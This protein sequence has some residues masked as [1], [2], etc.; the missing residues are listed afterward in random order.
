M[1]TSRPGAPG[2]TRTAGIS[3]GSQASDGGGRPGGARMPDAG[4]GAT[5]ARSWITWLPLLTLLILLGVAGLR[6]VVSQPRWDGPLHREGVAIGVALEVVLGTLLVITLRR[7]SASENGKALNPAAV[8]A[9]AVKLRGV[10]IVVLSAG[11]IAAAVT[12]LV[13]L[14]L[15]LFG[16]LAQRS[17][18]PGQPVPTPKFRLP[19]AS[20]GHSST[21]HIPVAAL[22]YTLLVVVL[23]TG[24][25]ISIWLARRFRSPGGAPADGFIAE[26]SADLRE[27]VESGRSALQTVDDARA[28]IIACY[29]AMENRLAEGGTARAVADTP[30]E[31]L[32]RATRSGLVRGTAAA[33]LTALFYEARFSSH[34][35]GRAQRDAAERALDELAAGLA[36][37]PPAQAGAGQ[38]GAAQA[39]TA[40]QAGAPQGGAGP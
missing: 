23:L 37:T 6:G 13:G 7:R 20:P 5:A 16:G 15:H 40:A 3:G 22:L 17:R 26:D 29:L 14:H 33:R 28:A 39:G 34:P 36:Q 27:A 12:V 38:A 19:S 35:L 25:V 30:D 11:M 8:N 10:L 18:A 32:A 31:L 24:V 4:P 9:T 21:I 2:T 1:T